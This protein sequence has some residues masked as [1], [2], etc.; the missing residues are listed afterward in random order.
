MNRE[1][2]TAV[3]EQF[4]DETVRN[5]HEEEIVMCSTEEWPR[6]W[7]FGFQTRAFLETNDFRQ[8]L[9]GY[10]P[11]VAP[12]SGEPVWMAALSRPVDEQLDG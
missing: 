12:K 6:H 9:P 10:G 3:A 4:L 7:S 2:A 8:S 1:S 11:I 5:T